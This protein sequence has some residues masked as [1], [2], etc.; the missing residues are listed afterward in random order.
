M[1]R[2]MVITSLL[3]LALVLVSI[4]S[5]SAQEM[6]TLNLPPG[7]ANQT[8][9]LLEQ[10]MQHMQEMGMSPEQM[11]M[12]MADMQSMA[13]QLPPGIFLQL[14][15]LMLQLDME[16]MMLLHQEIHQGTLLQQPPGQILTFV[17][18]LVR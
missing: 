11:E 5:V 3:A 12:M 16:E 18:G 6:P 15:R 2:K 14:L 8:Q 7:I 10:M 9:P 1:F 4:G 13:D 17:R